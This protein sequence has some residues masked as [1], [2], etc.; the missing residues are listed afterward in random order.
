MQYKQN[1]AFGKSILRYIVFVIPGILLYLVLMIRSA[2]GP[3]FNWSDPQNLSN[4]IYHMRGGDFSQLMFSSSG[5]FSR[6]LKFFFETLPSEFAFASGLVSLA[7]LVILLRQNRQVF[8]YMILSMLFCLL[9][10]L[11]YN[12]RDIQSYF[13]LFYVL[14]GISIGAGFLLLTGWMVSSIRLSKRPVLITTVIGLILVVFGFRFNYD[15]NNNS[16][17]YVVEDITLNTL[18]NLEANSLFLTYDWGYV[19]PAALYYQHV[20]GKRNDLKIFIIRFLAA[21]WYLEMIKK[22]YPE[23]YSTCSKEIEEYIKVFQVGER[24]RIVKLNN[25]VKAFIN[26]NFAKFPVYVTYDFAYNKE[27]KPFLANFN[28][29]PQ[30]LVYRLRGKNE[31]YDNTAGVSSLSSAFRSYKPNSKEKEKMHIA[32]AG[33]YYDNAMYHYQNKNYLLAIRFLD[34]AIEMKGDYKDAINLKNKI[35]KDSKNL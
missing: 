2:S 18:N 5:V 14:T 34:K 13:L 32:T 6:N 35:L 27:M 19:Y 29:Q 3:Y 30:G 23:V 15:A 11:N 20:E 21:P 31:E 26:Y 17:N 9:Y 7:G 16:D 8:Y 33:L 10:S 24:T 25:L 12:I 4:L 22:Y 28:I 1:A